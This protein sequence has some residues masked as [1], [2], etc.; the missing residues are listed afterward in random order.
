MSEFYPLIHSKQFKRKLKETLD[1]IDLNTS[2]YYNINFNPNPHQVFLKKFLNPNSPYK[3]ILVKH[4]VG[5]GKT[6]TA[7]GIADAFKDDQREVIV[8]S[9]GIAIAEAFKKE[10]R[11]CRDS[12]NLKKEPDIIV[13]KA[14]GSNDEKYEKY[15]KDRYFDNKLIIIDEVHNLISSLTNPDNITT[16]RKMELLFGAKNSKFVMLTGTPMINGPSEL[17]ILFNLINGPIEGLKMKVTNA[18]SELFNYLKSNNYVDFVEINKNNVVITSVPYGFSKNSDDYVTKDSKYAPTNLNIFKDKIEKFLKDKY[19][20]ITISDIESFNL[21]LFPKVLDEFDELY[22]N[23]DA[24]QNTIMNKT[25]FQ[26]RIQGLVSSY[27]YTSIEPKIDKDGIT[28][29]EKANYPTIYEHP[30]DYMTMSSD[31]QYQKYE[32]ARLKEQKTERNSMIRQKMSQMSD[33]VT[34]YKSNSSAK[35]NVAFTNEVENLDED[36]ETLECSEALKRHFEKHKDN[37]SKI[38]AD[39]KLMSPKFHKVLERIK[40]SDN[41]INVIYTDFVNFEAG[42]YSLMEMMIASGYARYGTPSKKLFVEYLNT[43]NNDF[44]NILDAFNSPENENGKIINTLFISRSAAEGV[45][46]KNVR[47]LHILEFHWNLNREKQVIG[48]VSRYNSHASLNIEDR[49]V[50]VYKYL[51]RLPKKT[52]NSESLNK[53]YKNDNGITSDVFKYNAAIRKE[54]LITQFLKAIDEASIDCENNYKNNCI[55]HLNFHPSYTENY[56]T[57]SIDAPKQTIRI[58]LPPYSFIP[59]RL[60]KK[61]FRLDESTKILYR[62]SDIDFENKIA[63][64]DIDEKNFFIF[65]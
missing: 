28:I 37:E 1:K 5:S 13:Y 11:S 49:N 39:I 31:N 35:C 51:S 62:E 14:L 63:L 29:T 43:S 6:C 60:H 16:S 64:L 41:E 56:Q 58:K 42:V 33:S 10:L 24:E 46:F 38:D 52:A 40:E 19:S 36:G 12:L 4:N 47:N 7:I 32:E 26:S 55:P 2:R 21:P 8:L 18:D 59:K 30:I 23:Q 34:S 15:L 57:K 65:I 48:R 25:L 45:S 20:N 54:V 22:V 3:G 44:N 61:I 9:P 53:M 50:N 27:G 17:A